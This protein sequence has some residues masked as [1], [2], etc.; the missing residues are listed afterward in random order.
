MT[1]EERMIQEYGALIALLGD[2]QQSYTVGEHIAAAE[3]LLRAYKCIF[4]VQSEW[5]TENNG[6]VDGEG[7][8]APVRHVIE[9]HTALAAVR[10]SL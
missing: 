6:T 3:R 8:L 5:A 7:G 1:T 2:G 10:A 9:M 4:A